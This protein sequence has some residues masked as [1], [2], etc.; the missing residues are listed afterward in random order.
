MQVLTIGN[1]L[2]RERHE[3]GSVR[4]IG[5]GKVI[6]AAILLGCCLGA[7]AD[8]TRSWRFDQTER[9]SYIVMPSADTMI[10]S[11]VFMCPYWVETLS[12]GGVLPPPGI[13]LVVR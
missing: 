3:S 7:R 10:V 5:W 13:V 6:S 9:A 11:S 12:K 1:S 2:M 4:R 8:V